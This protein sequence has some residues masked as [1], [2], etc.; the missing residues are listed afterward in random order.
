MPHSEKSLWVY[1]DAIRFRLYFD[2]PTRDW[3]VTRDGGVPE[4]ITPLQSH[5][6]IAGSSSPPSDDPEI[7]ITQKSHKFGARKVL[8]GFPAVVDRIPSLPPNKI[9]LIG[10]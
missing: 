2:S 5:P 8:G 4:F 10:T 9:L 6:A 3:H 1:E 7:K